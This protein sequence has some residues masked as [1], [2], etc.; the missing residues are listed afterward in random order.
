MLPVIWGKTPPMLTTKSIIYV[1]VLRKPVAAVGF[2]T[3]DTN[4]KVLFRNLAK[5]AFCKVSFLA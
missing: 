2:M 5:L 1:S 4:W 3:Y